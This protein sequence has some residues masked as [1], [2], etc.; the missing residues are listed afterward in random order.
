MILDGTLKDGEYKFYEDLGNGWAEEI[1]TPISAY[2]S[3]DVD[4]LNKTIERLNKIPD[5]NTLMKENNRL[6]NII[7]ELE[8]ELDLELNKTRANNEYNKGIFNAFRFIKDKLQ[9]LKEGK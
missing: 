4:E 7:N 3:I 1:K 2:G 5:Y 8:Y 6:N 9:E